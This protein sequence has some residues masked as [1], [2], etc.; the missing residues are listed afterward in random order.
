[1][2][3]SPYDVRGYPTLSVTEGYSAWAETYDDTVLDL[4]DLRIAE[5]LASV[6]WGEHAQALDLAC[7]TGR[8][9]AW[10]RKKGVAAVDGVDIT[11]AMLARAEARGAYR[12]LMSGPVTTVDRP[13]CAY[14][15]ICQSLADEHLPDLGPLYAEAFRLAAPGGAFVLLGYHP[16]FLM[17]GMPTHFRDG[18][19]RD[20]AIE[21][22]VHL[23]ADHAEAA[24]NAGWTLAELKEQLVDEAWIEAKPK[25]AVHRGRPISFGWVWRKAP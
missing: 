21:S 1:M 12:A 20:L 5:A 25:W 2:D 19:G 14:R 13:D 10:L 22:H 8:L 9:G 17:S 7:G 4:M 6:C 16:W 24:L 15:L 18:S 23:F 3:F 11:P